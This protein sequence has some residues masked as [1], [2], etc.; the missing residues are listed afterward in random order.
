MMGQDFHNPSVGKQLRG[1]LHQTDFEHIRT[2]ASYTSYGTPA[3][4][5]EWQQNAEAFT[6]SPIAD[7]INRVYSKSVDPRSRH[8]HVPVQSHVGVLTPPQPMLSHPACLH[9]H[10]LGTGTGRGDW[11]TRVRHSGCRGAEL[12]RRLGQRYKKPLDRYQTS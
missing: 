12:P 1:L 9:L 6:S 4:M 2:S 5:E 8:A 11:Q 10:R 3:A 7:Y